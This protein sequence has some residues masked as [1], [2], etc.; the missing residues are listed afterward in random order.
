MCKK[1]IGLILMMSL[2]VCALGASAVQPEP[3]RM[4]EWA[5][6]YVSEALY[7]G[8]LDDETFS[9][10]LQEEITREAFCVLAH[11]VLISCGINERFAFER[12]P[13]ADTQN[14]A[15]YTLYGLDI[16]NGVSDTEFA[17]EAF[18]TREE[19]AAI[20]HRMCKTVG[21]EDLYEDYSLSGYS[22]ADEAQFSHWAVSDI[23]S[24]YFL[25]IMTGV[26]D[27]CFDA[28]GRYTIEQA[29]ATMVRLYEKYREAFPDTLSFADKLDAGMPTDQNYMFSPLSIKM[30]LSLA[31]NGAMGQTRSEMLQAMDISDL[32]TYNTGAQ[33][34][35]EK[36]KQSENLR[37]D[38]ANSIW[39]NKNR[40]SFGFSEAFKNT[41]AEYYDAAA[42][43]V[44]DAD[45][46][47]AVNGWVNEKTNGKIPTIIEDSEFAALLLNAVYFK[48]AWQG[49]FSEYATKPDIFRNADGS[50]AET[51]FMNQTAHFSY[52]KTENAQIIELPYL[53][54]FS[55]FTEDGEY[56]GTENVDDIDVSMYLVASDENIAVEKEL[57]AAI[58]KSAFENQLVSLSV[59]KFEV[60]FS[61][62][63]NG[64]LKN[65]GIKTAFDKY[66]ADFTKMVDG[67]NLYI[68]DTIHKSYIKIDEKGTEAA[69]VTMI[70]F[71]P[72]S[73][74][75]AKE[76]P[77]VLKL[78]KPFS[79]VIRDNV[80]GETLFMGRF[81]F[82]V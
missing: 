17:P 37:L 11:S 73:V 60:E 15:V 7:L 31:A 32:L 69:A 79:F 46:V 68:D 14:N 23:Y 48:G 9:G 10:N 44:T 3:E 19:A 18:I 2:C 28:K 8:W 49:E 53:N 27:D 56:I 34:L 39:L 38:I 47:E 54:R 24:I 58:A 4:S 80:S 26:G 66:S 78:D 35:I 76:E 63:L 82:A 50:E 52:T 30:A 1:V 36:Y 74:A 42:R 81:A 16:V 57:E 45:A 61:I 29:I 51:D 5:D 77:I 25:N 41:A 64:L 71:E 72:T 22:F 33:A 67:G 43:E 70:A 21:I 6:P 75:P 55:Q 12:P 40:F 13:F 59:P 20:L 62:G 65:I